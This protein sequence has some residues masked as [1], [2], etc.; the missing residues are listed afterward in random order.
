LHWQHVWAPPLKPEGVMM[1]AG[2]ALGAMMVGCRG[3]T[4]PAGCTMTWGWLG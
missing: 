2:C 1:V 3:M 4:W